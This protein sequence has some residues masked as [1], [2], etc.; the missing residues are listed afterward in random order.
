[1]NEKVYR[2]S[3]TSVFM[4]IAIF[5]LAFLVGAIDWF[6]GKAAM[7]CMAVMSA[8]GL[9]LLIFYALPDNKPRV[10]IDED[11]ISTRDWGGFKILWVD[12]QD[13]KVVQ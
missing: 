4:F 3:L 13:V 1:M 11:G 8:F 6:N 12:I 7:G 10:A 9:I 2:R 5:T